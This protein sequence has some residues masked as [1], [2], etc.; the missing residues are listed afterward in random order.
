MSAM[1]AFI[2][3]LLGVLYVEM[4][5]HG[6]ASAAEVREGSESNLGCHLSMVL[7]F[8]SLG[9]FQKTVPAQ[10]PLALEPALGGSE[11]LLEVPSAVQF[12]VFFVKLAALEEGGSANERGGS[13]CLICL[14]P[15]P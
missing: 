6:N 15:F 8:V 11:P 1:L 3:R 2:P 4:L 14:P 12:S 7:S 9:R 10:T 5:V 13:V